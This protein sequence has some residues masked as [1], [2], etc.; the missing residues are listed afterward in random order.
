MI[1][2]RIMGRAGSYGKST[3]KNP[4]FSGDAPSMPETFSKKK[5]LTQAGTLTPFLFFFQTLELS[6]SLFPRPGEDDVATELTP[7]A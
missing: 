6:R 3:I 1:D 7:H 5:G 2:G 4:L